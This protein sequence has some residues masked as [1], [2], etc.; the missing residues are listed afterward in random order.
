MLPHTRFGARGDHRWR[1]LAVHLM[2]RRVCAPDQTDSRAATNELLAEL[3]TGGSRARAWARFLS[4]AGHRSVQQAL[5][6]P[7]AL[8]EVT[9]VHG[10]VLLAAHRRRWVVASW[11]LAATHLGMLGSRDALGVPNLLTLLR[12][13]LPAL[14]TGSG[15]WLGLAA[16]ACDFLDGWLARTSRT[17]THF[18]S[19]ADPLADAAF[20]THFA[21]RNEPS[22]LMRGMPLL[23]WGVPVTAVTVHTL[24]RGHMTSW[25]QPTLLRLGTAVQLLLSVRA[26]ARGTGEEPAVPRNWTRRAEPSNSQ[27]TQSPRHGSRWT[28]RGRGAAAARR[29]G[30]R[31]RWPQ[32]AS[33]R[34]RAGRPGPGRRAPPGRRRGS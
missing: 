12:A 8:T 33:A 26:A 29:G 18:G 2:R 10:A 31:L 27:L 13:N 7:R 5:L 23:V 6:H 30:L 24:R 21:L 14:G 15:R 9:L 4:R 25:P 34:F 19:Y 32:A 20:W 16:V 17:E 3:H 11:A 1:G 22:R 28:V